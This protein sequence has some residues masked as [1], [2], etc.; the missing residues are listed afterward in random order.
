[1]KDMALS[2]KTEERAWLGEVTNVALQQSM[3]DADQAYQD[4]F[5]R[6]A[7]K[8]AGKL[9][10]GARV[11]APKF[12]SRKDHRQSFRIV[13]RANTRV[14][15]VSRNRAQVWIPKIGWV[16]FALP[17]PCPPSLR[18]TR[19]CASRTDATT[20]PSWSTPCLPPALFRC[21]QRS[22]SIWGWGTW[23]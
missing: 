22:A 14:R 17:V 18:P 13:G 12:K 6:L 19:S 16:G 20:C 21:M 4:F 23:R 1:M 5:G 15:K 2:K 10:K 9:P 3:R 7:K 11:G 8:K